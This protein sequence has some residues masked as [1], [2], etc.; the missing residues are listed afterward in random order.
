MC[1]P[2]TV[3]ILSFVVLSWGLLVL[4]AC[5]SQRQESEQESAA[6]PTE[7]EPG[8]EAKDVPPAEQPR[9]TAVTVVETIARDP[10]L[11]TLARAVD[12]AGL[13]ETLSGPGPFT[14]LAP[15][16]EAFEKLPA[17]QLDGLLKDKDK[18]TTLLRHHVV[19]GRS[20]AEQVAELT[21][22]KSLA[23]KDLVIV[24]ADDG[25]VLIGGARVTGP[26]KIASNGVVH[27]IDLV[28]KPE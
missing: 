20:T 11:S 23:G 21:A 18:L 16:N 7:P 3:R 9:D 27:V 15:T 13:R 1:L 4:P 26:D 8:T 6:K 2:W 22:L 10:S 24:R 17:G 5:K 12:A 19:E 28:L 25:G 14:V